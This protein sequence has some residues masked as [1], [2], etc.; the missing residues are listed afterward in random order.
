MRSH[1][2]SWEYILSLSA[3]LPVNQQDV[4]RQWINVAKLRIDGLKVAFPH[5]REQTYEASSA[6]GSAT[7][8]Y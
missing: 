6:L 2:I 4:F 3:S 5:Q 8:Q 1:Q 7:E